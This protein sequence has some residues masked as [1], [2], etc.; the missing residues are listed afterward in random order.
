MPP[1]SPI[2]LRGFPN[3]VTRINDLPY[4]SPSGTPLLADL[5]LPHEQEAPFP[6]ILW[7]HAGGWI[8]GDRH[9]APDLSRYFAQRGFAMASIDYRLSREALFPAALHDVI[10]AI[11]WL[12]TV[13]AKYHLDPQRIG[14]WGASA[15]AHLA[16]LTVLSAPGTNVRAVVAAYPPTDFLQ[17]PKSV[18]NYESRF[19]GAPV[20][21]V[22]ELVRQANPATFAHPAA[23]PFLLLHSLADTEVPP[24]QSQLIYE[25]LRA[26]DTDVTLSTIDGMEHNFLENDLDLN[27]TSAARHTLRRSRPGEPEFIADAPPLTFGTIETFFRRHL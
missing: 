19:L 23:P 24:L 18:K 16:A 15:G 27:L 17:M 8:A 22:P 12:R 3:R 9:R 7:L 21:T 26:H 5:Y 10:A 2:I 13:S 4:S 6:V 25:A 14:L 11:H 1:L 20:E